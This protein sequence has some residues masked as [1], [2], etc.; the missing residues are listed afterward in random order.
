MKTL[1]YAS[2]I[3]L[4]ATTA[5][6]E[7]NFINAGSEEGVFKQMLDIVGSKVEHNFVQANTPVNA[8]TYFGTDPA[9]TV[10]SSE[11][12]SN[13][14]FNSPPIGADNLVA[15][16]TYDTLMCSREFSSLEEM[17]GK[18]V[19]VATWGSVA[20][21]KFLTKFGDETNIDFV[22]VPYDGSGATTKGYVA[23]DADT[24]FTITSKQP[25]IEEDASSKCFAFSANGDLDFKFVDAMITVNSDAST[26]ATL[27]EV[28]K[29]VSTTPEW[30]DAFSGSVTYVADESNTESLL[31]TYRVAIENFAQ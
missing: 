12:P 2:L 7:I 5:S 6:A 4:T 21:D 8:A 28:V 10:W 16:L 25:A 26:T 17:A 9:F 1:I 22:V 11:W 24:I 18:T 14:E 15:L 3:A 19:K 30:N 29:E 23:G 31:E 13:P 27:K 20:A